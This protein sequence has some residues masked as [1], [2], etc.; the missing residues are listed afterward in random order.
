[1]RKYSKNLR[2]K[3]IRIPIKIDDNKIACTSTIKINPK[4]GNIDKTHALVCK[5][6]NLS[7]N[8]SKIK[9]YKS[10]RFRYVRK[11]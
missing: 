9:M 3:T 11:T 4:T 1:M 5:N 6:N 2:C 7:Y 8:K 10:T